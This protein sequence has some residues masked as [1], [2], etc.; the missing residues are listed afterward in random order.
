MFSEGILQFLRSM[1]QYSMA[2]H[3]TAQYSMAQSSTA[4]F[5][6]T[7]YR[8]LDSHIR[9]SKVMASN[10]HRSHRCAGGN[11]CTCRRSLALSSYLILG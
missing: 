2:Q 11:L 9:G 3:S 7:Q 4:Q 10:G 6:M 1:A 5:S 8:I